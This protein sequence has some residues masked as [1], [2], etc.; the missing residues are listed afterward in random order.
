[1]STPVRRQYLTL[2]A[3][4]PN[5]ILFFRLGDF[6]EMFDEDALVGSRELELHLTSREFTKG[7][8]APMCGVPYHAAETHIA[9]LVSRGYKVAV[10]EQLG[11]P[12]DTKGKGLVEREVVRVVTPGTAVEGGLLDPRRNRYLAAALIKG[13]DAGVAY[14]DSTTGEI[15]TVAL[16]GKPVATLVERE[17]ARVAPTEIL[18][19]STDVERPPRAG[20]AP[21][22][23]DE[24][25]A[26]TGD[27]PVAPVM[28][29]DAFVTPYEPR[30]FTYQAASR[31]I[32]KHYDLRALDGQP[33]ARLPLAIGAVGAL[34]AYLEQTQR[35][36]LPQ[37]RP[38]AVH[39]PEDHMA[40]DG[41][42]RRNLEI[43]RTMRGG[44]AEGS[45]LWVLDRTKTAMG[46][47]LLRRW[48]TSPLLRLAPLR[49]RQDAVARLVDD[50]ALRLKLTVALGQLPDL[51]RL[52][53]KVLQSTATPRDLIALKTALE[54]A[55]ALR[56]VVGELAA[57][58]PASLAPPAPSGGAW[59]DASPQTPANQG[60]V[61]GDG[62]GPAAQLRTPALSTDNQGRVGGD[63]QGPRQHVSDSMLEVPGEDAAMGP[64]LGSLV[65]ALDGHADVCDLIVRAI[66]DDPKPRIGDGFF[67]RDGYSQE[68][69]GIEE[70]VKEARQWM[71]GLEKTEKERTGIRSLKVTYNKVFGYSIEVSHANRELVPP[72]YTRKQTL[73]NAERYI[74]HELKE[75]EG[76]ILSADERRAAIEAALLAGLRERIA[77]QAPRLLRTAAAIAGLDVYAGLATVAVERDYT[78]PELDDGARIEIVDGRHPVVEVAQRETPFVPNGITLDAA[79]EQIAILT[80]PNM[81]GKSC[82]LRQTALIVLLAQIGSFVPAARARIGMVDRV[83]TRVGAQDD[84]ATGHSTFM[85]E[86]VETATILNSCTARSLLILDEIGRG[87]STY[88]GVAIAQAIVEH[89]HETPRRAA[90]TIFATHYHEL[91][92]LAEAFSRVRNYRMDVLEEGGEVCFLRKVVPGGADKSYGIH[93]AELAGIP[94][95][96]V[97]RARQILRELEK[98]ARAERDALDSL[99][100]SFFA[101]PLEP[102]G[103]E[104]DGQ[105]KEANSNGQ[106]KEAN[107]NGYHPGADGFAA[108]LAALDIDGMTPLEALTTLAGL[109]VRARAT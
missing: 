59:G 75:K 11:D 74:T 44:A 99:Q 98:Q 17:L 102:R 45:L 78:R 60:R 5:A 4:F 89:L 109:H 52:T 79:E 26:E 71:A 96:V 58:T 53:G 33:Y 70:Q 49:A 94:K 6:Y 88:D 51:E 82:F 107:G 39:A 106:V 40:L 85:V 37:L 29:P 14:V 35:A 25:G 27:K 56:D 57:A 77:A 83:F 108:E 36:L 68:L 50:T 7:E 76:L 42:T 47:R 62:Q 19:P 12:R 90:R 93:V 21:E 67:I 103:A 97:R 65:E 46:A 41:P 10:C 3:Q 73:V 28:I 1:M 105:V 18:W 100:L 32:M 63:G 66:V 72:D 38:I 92:T 16:H 104:R 48:V 64:T 84:I 61:G 15:S 43:D 9:R 101:E 34:L 8:R 24:M 54:R 95:E 31:L 69:D 86:M 13:D 91:N 20:H 81:S 87:T 80:G 23:V 2:K 55:A 22:D 30:H